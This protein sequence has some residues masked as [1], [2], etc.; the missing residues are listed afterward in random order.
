MFGKSKKMEEFMSNPVRDIKEADQRGYNMN[1][2][3]TAKASERVTEMM[4]EIADMQR[5]GDLSIMC[6]VCI[7]DPKEEALA[8]FTL[9]NLHE[10]RVMEIGATMEHELADLLAVGI[11]QRQ[12]LQSLPVGGRA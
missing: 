11:Q 2:K 12:A 3:T 7:L 5:K 1:P 8:H 6:A 9:V 10:A 4:Q